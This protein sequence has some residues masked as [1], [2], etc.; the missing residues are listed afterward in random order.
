MM[1]YLQAPFPLQWIVEL[2][3]VEN[4]ASRNTL[5]LDYVY[6]VERRI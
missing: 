2:Y 5:L 4:A 6:V 1:R 3:I